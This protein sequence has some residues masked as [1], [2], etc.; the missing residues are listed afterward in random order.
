MYSL[1]KSM[2]LSAKHPV[3]HLLVDLDGTLL[4]NRAVPLSVDFVRQTL[5]IFRRQ[6]GSWKKALSTALAI[7]KEFGRPSKEHTNDIR[8]IQAFSNAMNL[9]FEEGRRVLREMTLLIF[10]S[11]QRHFFPI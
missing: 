5:G 8:V 10:P 4:G 1:Q 6:Y 3:K 9:S 7:K 2:E 11:L